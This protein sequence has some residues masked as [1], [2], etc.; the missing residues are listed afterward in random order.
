MILGFAI[1]AWFVVV[2]LIIYYITVYDYSLDVFRPKDDFETVSNNPNPVDRVFLSSVRKLRFLD[3]SQ[4]SLETRTD[5]NKEF[6]KVRCNIHVLTSSPHNAQRVVV[7][8]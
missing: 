1:T 3:F 8:N 5:I 7:S 4:T 6:N 2:L